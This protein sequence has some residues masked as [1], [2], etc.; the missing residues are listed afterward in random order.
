MAIVLLILLLLSGPAA[1]AWVDPSIIDA[2]SDCSNQHWIQGGGKVVRIS[3]TT[4][5]LECQG[6]N[7]RLMRSTNNGSSWTEIDD[8]T[9]WSGSLITGPDNYVYHFSKNYTAGGWIRMVKFLYDAE[10]IDAPTTIVS[11]GSSSFGDYSLVNATIDDDGYIYV[12]Y[13]YIDGAA[14]DSLFCIRSF[15]GGSNWETPVKIKDGTTGRWGFP[16]SEV[17]ANGDIVLVYRDW[18]TASGYLYFAISDDNGATWDSSAISDGTYEYGNPSILTKGSDIYVFAQSGPS[19]TDGLIFTKSTDGGDNW[20][21]WAAIQSYADM[22]YADPMPALGSDGT[23]YV[24][25][26]GAQELTSDSD[27]LRNHIAQ[28]TDDGA[29]WTFPFYRTLAEHGRAGVKSS[30]RYQTFWNYGGPF[31]W[32]WL[33]EQT[34]DVDDYP[35]MYDINAEV[36]I[37]SVESLATPVNFGTGASTAM[38]AGTSVIIQ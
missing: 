14:S 22:G 7:E 1:A 33:E 11:V 15:D 35:T 32:I 31:E 5:A 23:I 2:S 10:S 27:D 20:S 3:G 25:F 6:A 29:N 26:R 21:S 30:I 36:T 4:V 16:D 12:F 19:N 34:E 37:Y 24:T 17:R 28:S 13:H 8:E 18:T 9:G 38:S